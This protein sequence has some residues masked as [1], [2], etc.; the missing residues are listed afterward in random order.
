MASCRTGRKRS[1]SQPAA[2]LCQ[3]CPAVTQPQS[4]SSQKE[5]RQTWDQFTRQTSELCLSHFFFPAGDD[6]DEKQRNRHHPG[7]PIITL[8]RFASCFKKTMLVT[9][10]EEH[11]LTG[12]P[13]MHV[14]TQG[15]AGKGSESARTHVCRHANAPNATQ[16]HIQSHK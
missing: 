1:R 16:S 3:D 12:R 4:F 8:R 5:L 14:V 15:G 11:T 7:E 2:R 6:D 10:A 13:Q 9:Q